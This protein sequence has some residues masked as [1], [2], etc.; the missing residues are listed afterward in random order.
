VP[1]KRLIAK[2]K[3]HGIEGKIIDWI[4]NWLSNRRQRV[5]LN[6]KASCWKD[7]LSGVLQGSVLGPIC[8]I[9]F[10]ND[11]D[12]V[13]PQ[14]ECIKKFADDSKAAHPARD[15]EDKQAL[16]DGLDSMY[17]WT[18]DWGMEFNIKKCKTLHFGRNNPRHSYTLNGVEL[19]QP[20]QEVDVG[21]TI[22]TSLKPSL[23]C[24]KA[25]KAAHK[26]LSN[27]SRCFHFRDRY[28]FLKLYKQHVR[29]HLEYCSSVWSPWLQTDINLLEKVQIRAVK[30]ISGLQ[31][32]TYEGRLKEL[33]L[34]SLADR[35]VRFDM[36]QTYKILR[37]FDN[38]DH[39]T[40]FSKVNN[41]NTRLSS[42]HLNLQPSRSN[43]EIRRNFFS[44]RVV[45]TWNSL[46]NYVKDSTNPSTF[47]SNYDKHLLPII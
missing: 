40:W 21:V 36:I 5:I 23:Q 41:N 46:P 44:Q 11:L 13:A 33:N 8:F 20:D 3:A 43:H 17:R 25:S 2:L 19:E 47:K 45:N 24:I 15:L 30:M 34:Q 39:K 9:I 27:I 29:C 22:H 1:K 31:S 26:K 32:D 35:R 12:L 14:V 6:G 10:I 37:G 28:T 42:F 16:Q 38:V 4:E 7:V 18:Q